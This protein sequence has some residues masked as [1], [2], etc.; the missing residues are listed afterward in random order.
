[1]AIKASAWLLGHK[2]ILIA[3]ALPMLIALWWAFRPEKLWINQTVNEPAPFDTSA[4]PEPVFT[5]QFDGKTGGRVTVFKKP[6]GT[7]YLRLSGL[8][9][10]GDMDAQVEL[11]RSGDRSPAQAESKADLDSID[12]GP[13]KGN[14][15]DQ[16][17]DLPAGADLTRYNAVVIRN[18]RIGSVLGLARLD[19]F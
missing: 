13:L 3:A 16:I 12:L 1:M 18:K 15:G 5:G 8:T 17:Y 14:Q 10:P 2:R 7:E 11:E 9:V 6:G 4:D 19:A